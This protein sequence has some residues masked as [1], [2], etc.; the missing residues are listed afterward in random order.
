MTP[1]GRRFALP[2][3]AALRRGRDEAA[4]LRATDG[5]PAPG[6]RSACRCRL[7]GT[8]RSA[9]AHKPPI[10]R[11][12][13]SSTNTPRSLTRHSAWIG[14][15]YSPRAVAAS[16]IAVDDGRLR[17]R[18]PPSTA[19]RRWFPRKTGRRAGRACRKSRATSSVPRFISALERELTALDE[20][21]RPAPVRAPRRARP[22]VGRCQ[23]PPHPSKAR[24]QAPSRR[25]PA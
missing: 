3:V 25:P 6:D 12:A 17:L 22:N 23:E 18:P 4:V 5:S 21:L 15:C 9:R 16:A 10:G 1:G 13:T 19:S 14:P 24:R 8:N 11:A 2:C 20:L 7:T